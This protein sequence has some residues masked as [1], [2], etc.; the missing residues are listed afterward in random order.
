MLKR[1]YGGP[2]TI[3]KLG[4]AAT[5][6]K[7]GVKSVTKTSYPIARAI[8]LPVRMSKE[9]LRS[10]SQ[11]SAN[12]KFTSGATFEKGLRQIIVDR[13]DVDSSL[14]LTT[15]DWLVFNDRRYNIKAV[16]EFEFDTAW[17]ITGQE[18]GGVTPEQHHHAKTDSYLSLTSTA[19]A[20]L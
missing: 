12:K 17:V 13:A 1:Q 2:V 3:Y 14:E 6:Y 7:T 8:I 19:S 11:I 5:N 9:V 18:I 10:I 16:E 20:E 4:D 15:D